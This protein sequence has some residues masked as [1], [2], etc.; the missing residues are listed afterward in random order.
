MTAKSKSTFPLRQDD[1]YKRAKQLIVTSIEAGVTV[2]RAH[3]EVDKTVDNVCLE[4][5]IR[6]KKEHNVS[7]DVQI[8]GEDSST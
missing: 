3:V 1:L 8:A 6:L 2:M 4:T 5:G 7:C